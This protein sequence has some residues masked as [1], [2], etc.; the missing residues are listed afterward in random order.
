MSSGYCFQAVD[1]FKHPQPRERLRE[2]LEFM[3]LSKTKGMHGLFLVFVGM[4]VRLTK[5]VCPPELVQEAVGTVVGIV[6]HHAERFG[7]PASTCLRPADT[8]P[9]WQ[10]GVVLCDR[11]PLYVE[12]CFDGC[13]KDYTGLGRPG[14]WFVTPSKD[15]WELPISATATVDHP[16]ARGKKQIKLKAKRNA[17]VEV[18]RCQLALT[19]EDVKTYQNIQ[20]QTV[21]CADGSAKGLVVDLERPRNMGEAE[22]FQHL[23]MV[24]GR[25]R[26]LE[27]LLLRN[28]PCDEGGSPNWS[29]FERGPPG[30]LCEFTEKL[31]QRA[32][33]TWPR[34]LR[35]QCASGMPAFEDLPVCAPDPDNEGHFIY[36]PR[37]VTNQIAYL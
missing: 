35:A 33:E 6:F 8:H 5:K 3:N 15:T 16:N 27:W 10:A 11:L 14:V 7:H 28:F 20:G 29:I 1:R 31:K 30:Y 34:L 23:Y 21:K 2:A 37:R 19:H 26:K 22:Y 9:C 12:V 32:A 18:T 24:L 36:D 25:A 4:R 13:S 17:T